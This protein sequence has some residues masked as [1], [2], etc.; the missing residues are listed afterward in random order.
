MEKSKNFNE[1][2][3]NCLILFAAELLRRDH[4]GAIRI[5]ET[6][7]Q[8]A[9]VTNDELVD[10]LAESDEIEMPEQVYDCLYDMYLD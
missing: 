7:M 8:E 1:G 5:I 2:W 10:V 9:G 6:V 4:R 3:W